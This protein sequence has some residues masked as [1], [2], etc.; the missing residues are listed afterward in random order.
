MFFIQR[1][2]VAAVACPASAEIIVIAIRNRNHL[3]RHFGSNCVVWDARAN[4]NAAPPHATNEAS[5]KSAPM[6]PLSYTQ[7][8][9][10]PLR[11]RVIIS[12]IGMTSQI[13]TSPAPTALP[14]EQ[15]TARPR[16]QLYIY[17]LL[18]DKSFVAQDERALEASICD[19]R[20]QHCGLP[21]ANTVRSA[22]RERARFS[23][24]SS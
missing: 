3:T 13:P 9:R 11:S 22:S 18:L 20:S 24:T 15:P 10:R 12:T 6:P 14:A 7:R 4:C 19:V 1:S 16:Y 2:G 8:Q 5:S 17:F 23:K 21:S